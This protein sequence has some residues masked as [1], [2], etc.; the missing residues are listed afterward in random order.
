MPI[1]MISFPV[2]EWYDFFTRIDKKFKSFTTIK[3][4]KNLKL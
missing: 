4:R 2:S 3:A 1:V